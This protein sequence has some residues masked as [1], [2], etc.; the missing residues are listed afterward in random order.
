MRTFVLVPNDD[1]TGA[2]GRPSSTTLR[3]FNG[4][5]GV[6]L[7]VRQ[8]RR[9]AMVFLRVRKI[10]VAMWWKADPEAANRPAAGRPAVGRPDAALEILSARG[11]GW[12]S[13]GHSPGPAPAS[14]QGPGPEPGPVQR[15]DAIGGDAPKNAM[16]RL[17]RRFSAALKGP[18][19]RDVA[20]TKLNG[21]IRQ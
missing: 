19:E 11:Q 15:Q 4:L 3:L 20:A 21:K 17:W 10:V 6:E 18:R 8:S 7:G 1:T 9:K 13:R 14:G 2:A 12:I 16:Q 5:G